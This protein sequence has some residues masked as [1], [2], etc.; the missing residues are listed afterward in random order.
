MT[1]LMAASC[2]GGRYLI[3]NG[4][5]HAGDV[6]PVSAF[7]ESTSGAYTTTR[8]HGS[9][10][11]VL[12]WERHLR[13]LADSAQILAGSRPEFFGSDHPRARFQAVSAAIRPFVEESL[14]AGLGLALRERDRAGSTEE[15]AI[16]ALVRGSEEEEDGLDVFL[17]IGFFIPPVFGTA[18]AHLAVAGRGRDV[19]AAKYSDWAR[20]RKGME[21]M[22]PP[23]VT[24]LLLTNDGDRILEGS[25]TNFFVVCRKV[26]HDMT[27]EALNDP[28]SARLFEVQTAPLSDG[29]LPGVIRQ[30]VI[31]KGIPLQEVAPS[32][33]DR[34]LWKEAF[35]TSS[36]RLLQH[37]ETIQ[38][39]IS[40]KELHLKKTWKDASWEVKRFKGVGLITTE[41]QVYNCLF[42]SMLI[43][44]SIKHNGFLADI[45]EIYN[46]FLCCYGWHLCIVSSKMFVE[47]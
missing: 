38:A 27:D 22:R 39:P 41:I 43:V 24:E 36:L 28:E 19:A 37:V 31:D 45:K 25:V 30:L 47:Y 34:E 2:R 23:P 21:K 10:A 4:V 12:F 18:G 7:L 16:T 29:V 1:C 44:I 14:R 33:S 15:L 32:W 20:I 5:P 3:V 8:T 17:H 9:A 26:V 40:F 42:V 6:P 11:L 35:V 46:T 13:R